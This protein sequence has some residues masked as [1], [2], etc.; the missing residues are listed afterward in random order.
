MLHTLIPVACSG[1]DAEVY[2]QLRLQPGEGVP[3]SVHATG[4]SI[5]SLRNELGAQAA[6]AIEN[7]RLFGQAQAFSTGVPLCREHAGVHQLG[8]QGAGFD[9]VAA[10][11]TGPASGLDGMRE[12]TRLLGGQWVV[13]TALGRGTRL[14]AECPVGGPDA[15][16][17]NA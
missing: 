11:A 6:N 1:G 13:E 9:P 3:G 7:A 2:R 17:A 12:R 8:D 15:E 14:L 4:D 16:R 5:L 10:L